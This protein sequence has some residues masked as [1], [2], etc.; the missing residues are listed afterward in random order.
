MFD[1]MESRIDGVVI[2]TPDHCHFHPAW[3]AMQ[4]GKHVYLEKP[5]A[6]CVW[7]IRE[8]TKLAAEKKIATQ[9]GAQRHAM[10]ALR[11][12]VEIVQ[13][14]TIGTIKECHS[15]IDSSRGMP[16]PTAGPQTIPSSLKW[17]LWLGPTADRPYS[18]DYVPYNWRFWWDFGTGD[19]GNWGCHILDIPYWALGLK[20]PTH[21]EGSGPT[22][23]P[24][25]TPKSLTTR[26]DF[27]AD[28]NRP[29]VSLHWYQGTPP[30]LKQLGLDGKNMNNL[31]IGADGMLLCGFGKY[32]L[33]PEKKFGG[34]KKPAA[35]LPPSP[36]FHQ[37]WFNACR[38]GKPATCNFNYSGPMAE[39]VLLANIAYRVQGNFDW[40][41]ATLSP[42]GDAA[43]AVEK[44]LRDPFRKGWE[45]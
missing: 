42:T 5:L 35:T 18:K 30:I 38:G 15:W 8:L 44:Y 2:S 12:G 7:E 1:E 25:R 26:L 41:A 6:H 16:T 4:R 9:L 11:G 23:D 27:P 33:L 3:W 19:T 28:G 32:H 14:G 40:N 29:A 34:F 43:A 39:T 37:E 31:F 22:P 21:V 45:I 20:Y 13:A 24:Q 36:G 17:D 10:A